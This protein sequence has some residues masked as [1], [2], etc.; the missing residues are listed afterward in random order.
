MSLFRGARINQ[1]FSAKASR[2]MVKKLT[3][4]N[5]IAPM[6]GLT[7]FSHED[8]PIFRMR[9]TDTADSSSTP[10]VS[11]FLQTRATCVFELNPMSLLTPML[12]QGSRSKSLCYPEGP[13]PNDSTGG[14]LRFP[15]VGPYNINYYTAQY[16]RYLVLSTTYRFLIENYEDFPVI[17]GYEILPI[18]VIHSVTNPTAADTEGVTDSS[19]MTEWG[20]EAITDLRGLRID[21]ILARE[22]VVSAV[23]PAG[24]GTVR[25]A[26]TTDAGVGMA[27]A[28]LHVQPARVKVEFTVENFKILKRMARATRP[29]MNFASVDVDSYCGDYVNAA[30]TEPKYIVDGL[31]VNP[32]RVTCFCAPQ[33][34]WY[35]DFGG[36]ENVN[37]DHST[38][39]HMEGWGT[40]SSNWTQ[41]VNIR[42]QCTQSVMLLDPVIPNVPPTADPDVATG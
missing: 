25:V 36:T 16:G 6:E 26:G 34:A 1:T 20:G 14:D 21:E 5:N 27:A 22:N 15:D 39:F 33:N 28:Q 13:A 35:T 4:P 42:P 9:F 32:V 8:L 23:I 18:N 17:F 7:T 10:T 38:Q 30:T 31:E 24:R 2:R 40:L 11:N 3:N 29:G 37:D 12:A 41:K 19:Q